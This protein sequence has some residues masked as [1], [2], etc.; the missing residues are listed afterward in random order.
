M[1]YTT[2]GEEMAHTIKKDVFEIFNE[3]SK[4]T[5]K[6]GRLE[7]LNTY[8][9]VP[10]LTDILRGT[11][12]D[13]L[14]FTLPEGTPPYTPNK[15]ESTPSNLL[16]EHKKFGYF[17]KGGPGDR[18]NKIKRETMFIRLLESIHPQDAELVLAMVAKKSPVKFL[19]KKL[20]QEAF[21]NLIKT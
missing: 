10:A 3:F 2:I 12:D 1:I 16:R 4:Q 18:L 20:V 11:F 9:K 19:T 15:P 17:V 8:S 5:T 21:P 6:K 14:Q 7:V 13:A